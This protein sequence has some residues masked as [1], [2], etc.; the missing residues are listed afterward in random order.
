MY[1]ET[2]LKQLGFTQTTPIQDGVF[3]AISGRKHI[4]GLAPTGTGKTHAYL[5]PIL[6]NMDFSKGEVQAVICVPT[7]ELVIQV[8][9][10]LKDVENDV[11]VRAYYGGSNKQR[12]QEWLEKYQP[13][14]VVTTPQRLHDYVVDQNILKIQTAKFFV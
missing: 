10:M 9:K 6:A 5:L 1:I 7:N 8:E 12:E 2:K 4:V 3:K 11:V 14:I 13:Q